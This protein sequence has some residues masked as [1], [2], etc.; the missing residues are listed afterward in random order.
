MHVGLIGRDIW[1]PGRFVVAHIKMNPRCHRPLLGGGKAPGNPRPKGG[2]QKGV[3]HGARKERIAD[4]EKEKD[5]LS[6]RR[7]G[8]R[9]GRG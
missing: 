7:T 6:D 8:G 2:G 3:H 5:R 4:D 1:L 9:A